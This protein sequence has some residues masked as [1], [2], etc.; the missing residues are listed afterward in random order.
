[1]AQ[2]HSLTHSAAFAEFQGLW[3]ARMATERG[4]DLRVAEALMDVLMSITSR[5]NE[6]QRSGSVT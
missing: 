6:G 4:F 3:E 5:M 1:M 2:T